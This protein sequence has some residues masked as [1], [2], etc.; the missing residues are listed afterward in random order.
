MV[1]K[2]FLLFL[3]AE[4]DKQCSSAA[5]FWFHVLDCDGDGVIS[6]ADMRF[7]YDGLQKRLNEM[8]E[9][10][11]AFPELL[12]EFNDMISP[13]RPSRI[14]AGELRRCPLSYNIISAL[15]NVRKFI[16]WE[17]LAC[18]KAAGRDSTIRD[19]T[20]WDLFA[21]REYRRLSEADEDEAADADEDG[22]DDSDSVSTEGSAGV[23]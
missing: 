13:A 18:A 7:F 12:N 4:E 16:A 17:G 15:T 8:D 10:C 6:T 9:D 14:T 21:D 5:Q 20:D 19:T 23:G 11:V 1:W 22:D 2:D 3:L